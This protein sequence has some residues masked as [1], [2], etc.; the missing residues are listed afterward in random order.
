MSNASLN[1]VDLLARSE[2]AAQRACRHMM[3]HYGSTH[4]IEDKGL[5]SPTSDVVTQ[6][7]HQCQALILETLF[8]GGPSDP[9]HEQVAVLAEE[10]DDHQSSL[11]ALRDHSFVIDPIDGTRGYVD[12]TG[13]FAV[14]IALITRAGR[15]VFG[16]A[17]LPALDMHLVAPPA[18]PS[19]CNSRPLERREPGKAATIT[20]WVSE[21]EIFPA[22]NNAY[23]H[24]L[25]ARLKS[26]LHAQAIRPQCVASPVHKGCLV[27]THAGPSLYVGLPRANEGVSLWDLAAVAAIVEKAGGW[28]SDIF[29]APLELNRAQSTYLHH[30]GFVLASSPSLG[31]AAIAV[32]RDWAQNLAKG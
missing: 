6:V 16:V 10:M 25:S 17:N 12:R 3:Q 20:L 7:D 11:R 29:G 32:H 21:A 5:G 15:P 18:G 23:F 4:E 28:V 1:L 9:L 13:S 14:S 8:P 27:A 30:K 31:Q 26:Q 22:R 19:H 24:Q 2:L